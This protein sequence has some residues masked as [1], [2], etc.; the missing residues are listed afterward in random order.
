MVPS[1]STMERQV[2]L[3]GWIPMALGGLL[4]WGCASN[5]TGTRASGDP[6]PPPV[7]A[8]ESGSATTVSESTGT[9]MACFWAAKVDPFRSEPPEDF[10]CLVR[11]VEPS[12]AALWCRDDESCCE[13]ATCSA[14]GLCV[15][16]SIDASS[17]ESTLL[18]PTAE[19]SGASETESP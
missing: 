3:Y 10:E 14:L 16:G 18:M 7:A 6:P 19:T 17:G 9:E 2:T 11:C 1:A 8:G 13:E 5:D 12:D 4:W 15:A